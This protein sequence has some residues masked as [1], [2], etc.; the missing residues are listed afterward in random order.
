MRQADTLYRDLAARIERAMRQQVRGSPAGPVVGNEHRVGPDR[1][2]DVHL[3][4]DRRAPCRDLCPVTRLDGVRLRQARM[5]LD[6]GLGI[7]LDER[8]DAPGLRAREIVAH[9][10]AG[11]EQQRERGVDRVAALAPLGDLEVRLP[12]LW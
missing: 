8:T 3:R 7:L 6:L 10:A 12:S 9:D 11:R 4:H 5:H 1:L 2:D